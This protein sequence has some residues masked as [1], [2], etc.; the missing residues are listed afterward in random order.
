M[1]HDTKAQQ[2]GGVRAG[3]VSANLRVRDL[4]LHAAGGA[5]EALAV[6]GVAAA[7]PDGG[8]AAGDLQA[9]PAQRGRRHV[10]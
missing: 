1:M 3:Q 9:L 10:Y 8:A 7:V 2:H 4:D 5:A 6:V